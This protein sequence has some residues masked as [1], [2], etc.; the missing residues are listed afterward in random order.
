MKKNGRDVKHRG[1]LESQLYE[2]SMA[3]T[4]FDS[5]AP[6]A[7]NTSMTRDPG[8]NAGLSMQMS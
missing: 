7:T 1:V 2:G 5:G 8:A 4:N 6:L 3:L